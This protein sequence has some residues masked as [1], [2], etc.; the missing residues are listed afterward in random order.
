[1]R[2]NNQTGRSMVE[3]LGVL[4]I[5]GV[6]SV[7]SI[8]GYQKAMTKYK[9]NK[10]AEATN[11]LINNSLQFMA[12]M[13]KPEK[14]Y[15]TRV[16]YGDVFKKLGLLP[17]GIEYVSN[18][19]LRD[20]YFN[21]EMFIYQQYNNYFYSGIGFNFGE[22]ANAMADICRNIVFAAKEN[23]ENLKVVQL[24]Y[25]NGA[26]SGYQGELYGNKYCVDGK[27]CLSKLTLKDTENICLGCAQDSAC[28]LYILWE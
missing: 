24:R 23:A 20:K 28:E 13:P 6:L 26:A 27:K 5:I 12:S 18:M 2:K 1:M 15:A 25:V 3:M 16:Y 17:D 8:A 14:K 10:H 19:L 9:L 21:I 7:G 4:A 22:K 11:L